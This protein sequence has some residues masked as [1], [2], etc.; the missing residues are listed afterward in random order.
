MNLHVQSIDQHPVQDCKVPKAA[1]QALHATYTVG[2]FSSAS[3]T[4]SPCR[5]ASLGTR[6]LIIIIVTNGRLLIVF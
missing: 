2:A 1:G 5:L 3:K 6:S 4:S